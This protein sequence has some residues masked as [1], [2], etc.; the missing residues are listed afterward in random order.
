L[1]QRI[2][3]YREAL[4]RRPLPTWTR[5]HQDAAVIDGFASPLFRL[6]L[7]MVPLADDL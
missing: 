5:L 4:R 7:R 3:A 6:R 1:A 2:A